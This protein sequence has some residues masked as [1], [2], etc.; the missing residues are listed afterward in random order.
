V[1]AIIVL[2]FRC[3]AE[4]C[5]NLPARLR[6]AEIPLLLKYGGW[7]NLTSLLGQALIMTD[8]FMIGAVLGAAA[9]TIYTVPL[10]LAQ[11]IQILPGAL[12]N[13]MF[14][15]LSAL[16]G[17]EKN[18]LADA[19]SRTLL[20]IMNLPVLGAIFVAEPFL[21]LWLGDEIGLQSAPVARIV[22]IGFW[23]NS[24]AF[25][26]FIRLQTSGRPDLVAKSTMAQI[27]VYV[28]ALY[29]ALTHFSFLGCAIVFAARC[30]IDYL[31][32]TYLSQRVIPNW[33]NL[34]FSFAVLLLGAYLASLWSIL[35]WRWW[36]SAAVL[37]LLLLAVGWRT[38]P[39]EIK[40]GPM[41]GRIRRTIAARL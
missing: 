17:E 13:A 14:P 31:I 1:V 21:R 18:K 23:I 40:E 3:Y 36:T 35:D 26:S 4:F 37:G 33:L 27:P 16:Q 5:R 9:V 32:L 30:W 11:R 29:F 12:T 6:R 39:Q 41:I 7:V 34:L 19:A 10:Q 28:A 20:A 25:V 38:L 22:L 2:L 8:R 24:F 15:R